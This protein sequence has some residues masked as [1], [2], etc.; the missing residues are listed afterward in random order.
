MKTI[1]YMRVSSKDQHLERQEEAFLKFAKDNNINEYIVYSDKQSGKDFERK[2]YTEM[3]E[4]LEK[5]DLVVIKSID[6]LGRN[7]DLIIQEWTNITKVIGA[8]IVVLDMPLLDT[9]EKQNN[10]TGK[11]ISDIVLQ[12]LSYVA[13]TER[14]NIKQRQKEGIAIAKANGVKFGAS[15]KI[16]EDLIGDFKLDYLNGM[17]Y[18]EMQV[19]YNLS[20]PSVIATAKRLGLESRNRRNK[21]CL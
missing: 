14:V 17:P 7:Y 20:K 9:R 6:R 15:V 8:D 21:K 18:A 11:F 12:L 10:L 13:E 2:G 4:N 16:S 19:K 1:S 3:V 5:G